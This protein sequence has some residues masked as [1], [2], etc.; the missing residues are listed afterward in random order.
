MSSQWTLSII[1]LETIKHVK[2]RQPLDEDVFFEASIL[3]FLIV[4]FL[5]KGT[6]CS[7]D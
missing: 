6:K 5:Y 3:H 1:D 4:S 7:S 2:Q